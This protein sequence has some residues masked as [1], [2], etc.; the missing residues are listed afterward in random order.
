MKELIGGIGVGII[1]H[2]DARR[3]MIE[4]RIAFIGT[5]IVERNTKQVWMVLELCGQV[6][7]KLTAEK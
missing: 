7:T 3:R 4:D 1:A 6:K 2:K 5:T